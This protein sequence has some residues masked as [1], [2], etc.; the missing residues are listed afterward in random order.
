MGPSFWKI[1][2]NAKDGI[3]MVPWLQYEDKQ[4]RVKPTTWQLENQKLTP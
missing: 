1:N 2:M 4:E 3:E